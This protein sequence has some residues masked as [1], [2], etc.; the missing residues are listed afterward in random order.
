MS[1]DVASVKQDKAGRPPNG[2]A[3]Y[4]N[5]PLF[6]GSVFPPNGGHVYITNLP[7]WYF[8]VFAYKLGGSEAIDIDPQLPD[9]AQH[10]RFDIEAQASDGTTK[11]QM[12]M[13]MRSLLEERFK[14]AA[15]WESKQEPVYDLVLMKPGKMGPQLR[16][17]NS[18]EAPC[19]G[20]PAATPY[21]TNSKEGLATVAGG[22]PAICGGIQPLVASTPEMHRIGSRNIKMSMFAS[23]FTGDATAVDRP[24]V[25]KTGIG[26][27]VDFVLEYYRLGDNQ[28]E[29]LPGPTFLEAIKKQLGLKLEPDTASV[30]RLVIDHVEEPTPN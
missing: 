1:F 30:R 27:N 7:L 22:F 24:I 20:A 3:P 6:A 9:W 5:F 4:S 15:H 17:Y 21:G 19:P 28:P 26:G 18:D 10:E 2:P 11:D 13:M 29:V 23:S 16:L 25:D 14:F 8:I 12:R